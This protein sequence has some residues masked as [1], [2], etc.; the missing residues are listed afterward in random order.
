M[1]ASS[2][3]SPAIDQPTFTNLVH[4]ALG[5][6]YDTSALQ[7]H[8]LTSLLSPLHLSMLL[9]G[10]HLRRLLLASIQAQRP[11]AGVPASSPDWRTYHLLEL[12]YIEGQNPGEAMRQLGLA[13]SQF[14]REQ[15]RGIDA[16]ATY[17]WGRYLNS[18][19]TSTDVSRSDLIRTE[20]ERLTAFPV[21][22]GLDDRELLDDLSA[23]LKPLAIVKGIDAQITSL[24]S[25][26][27]LVVDRVL[28]KQALLVAFNS[29][30]NLPRTQHLEVISSPDGTTGVWF[31]AQPISGTSVPEN[32]LALCRSLVEATGGSTEVTAKDDALEL[33]L[34]WSFTQPQTLLVVDDN[35]GLI[36]LFRRYLAGHSWRVLGAMNGI[37]AREIVADSLPHVIVLDVMMPQEDGWELL[38]SLKASERLRNIPVIVCSV[39]DQPQIAL[40]LG[41][42]AYLPKPVTQ[43]QLLHS[44]A[45][46]STEKG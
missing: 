24:A 25:L 21:Q 23:I 6:L 26:R 13:R 44:L 45:P 3:L 40:S 32:E 46:W 28:L 39:L 9:R 42:L 43:Q 7:R 36:D 8:P 18:Y 20:A 27:G 41:A 5:K 19:N 37:E 10:Q 38:Q 2:D 11:A 34:M 31:R 1:S 12:R 4:D 29:L 33:R 15:A 16:V 14:Y 30:L 35:A 22:H 17:L